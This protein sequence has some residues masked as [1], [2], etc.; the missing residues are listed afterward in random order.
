MQ[1]SPDHK[2]AGLLA[3]LFALRGKHDLGVGDLG[4]LREFVDWAAEQGFRV[5][6]LLPVN[7]TGNDNSPYNAISSVALDPLTIEITPEALPDLSAEDI[8]KITSSADLKAL[9]AGAVI[10]AEMKELK[11]VLLERAFENFVGHSWKKNDKRARAF[12]TFLRNEGAWLHGYAFFRVLVDENGGT[13]RWDLWPEEQRS[14]AQAQAWLDVQKPAKRH[15]FERQLRLVSYVQWIAWE[16]WHKMHDYAGSKGVA[17]MGD[18]PFGVSYYSADVWTR[19]ELFDHIWCGGCPPERVFE[20]DP[21]TYKWGQNWGIPLYRWEVHREQGFDWWRQRVRKVRACFHLFRIDHIL[22]FFR[23]YGFPWRPQLNAEFLPLTEEEAKERTHGE[24]PHYVPHEDDTAAHKAANCA[25]G[26]EVLKVLI[27]ECGPFRLIGEDLGVVPD[28]VRPC[29]T[30]LGIA[31]FKIPYW[32][33]EPDGHMT[34]GKAYQRLSV[35]TY[36]THDFEPL[37]TTWEGWMAKIE[38]AEHGGPE[39]HKGRDQAWRD[40]RRVAGWCGFDVPRITPYSDE[41]HEK[42][43]RGLFATNSWMAIYMITDLFATTQR[44]NVP[45]AVSESNWSR[46]MDEP[47]MQWDKDARRKAKMD[48]I[49]E[50]LRATGRL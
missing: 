38:A 41:I 28:Y 27:E 16:Q 39:T 15:Q 35:T 45:G 3:P 30:E 49:H 46:R 40:V 13:E 47:V 14:F 12:R 8:E 36:A 7:E 33:N 29:L 44:F 42:L 34:P 4:A 24:L 5:V 26:R 20:T 23:I 50:I 2:L 25:Q 1:L 32:E 10:Y 48:R 17:L 37:R 18:I 31:G 11:W 21:F 19:P 22:G 9:R 43:L 6:Q